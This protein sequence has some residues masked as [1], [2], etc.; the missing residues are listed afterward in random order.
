MKN[1]S[2][3]PHSIIQPCAPKHARTGLPSCLRRSHRSPHP[4]LH[5]PRHPGHLCPHS[6]HGLCHSCPPHPH[7]Q[8]MPPQTAPFTSPLAPSTACTC[9]HTPVHIHTPRTHAPCTVH[10]HTLVICTRGVHAV[11][12]MRTICFRMSMPHGQPC[13]HLHCVQHDAGASEGGSCGSHGASCCEHGLYCRQNYQHWASGLS[14][15]PSAWAD[16][17]V[18]PGL[19]PERGGICIEDDMDDDGRSAELGEASWEVGGM[20]DGCGVVRVQKHNSFRSQNKHNQKLTSLIPANL[21]SK[22]P[23][24]P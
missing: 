20:G 9:I 16:P 7:L 5:P 23:Y 18:D 14:F 24:P 8:P 15:L 3:S 21:S 19:D 13:I 4:P 12:T 6:D 22:L 1:P 10:V 2:L 17:C 11:R